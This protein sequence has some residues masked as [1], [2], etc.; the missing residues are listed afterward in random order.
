MKGSR[1]LRASL[2]AAFLLAF[3]A[4]AVADNC[5]GLADCYGTAIAAAKVAAG[6]AVVIGIWAVLPEIL[7]AAGIAEIGGAFAEGA[8]TVTAASALAGLVAGTPP[9]DPGQGVAA[10]QQPAGPLQLVKVYNG[11]GNTQLSLENIYDKDGALVKSF[12]GTEPLLPPDV[13]ETI[14]KNIIVPL[15]SEGWLDADAQEFIGHL[16]NAINDAPDVGNALL[17]QDPTKALIAVADA[18]GPDGLNVLEACAEIGLRMG[19]VSQ[20]T[21]EAIK[22]AAANQALDHLGATSAAE[23]ATWIAE[24][25]LNPGSKGS[26]R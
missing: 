7:A 3:P 25:V 11:D 2:T 9:A 14:A 1:V 21:V 13:L 10:S 16:G 17:D 4:L 23:L 19:G 8:E 20:Q 24:N 15:L 5:G 22:V 12:E 6:I 18:F 26:T